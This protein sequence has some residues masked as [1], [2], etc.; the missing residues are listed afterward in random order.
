M[1]CILHYVKETKKKKLLRFEGQNVIR[2]IFFL[3][4]QNMLRFT[5]NPTMFF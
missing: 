3:S 1:G 5:Y 2:C 4:G